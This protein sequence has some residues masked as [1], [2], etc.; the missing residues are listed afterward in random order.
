MPELPEVET[1]RR[2]I[3][4]SCE[5][6]TIEKLVLRRPDLRWPI[7]IDLAQQIEGHKILAIKRR[8]KY[9]LFELGHGTLIIH[10]GMSGVLKMVQPTMP[11]TKHDHVDLV[12]S[13]GICLRLNDTRRFGAVLWADASLLHPLLA[14]LGPEPLAEEFNAKLLF[15]QSRKRSIAIKLLI[16]DS[17]IVVG[18]GNIYANEALFHAKIHPETPANK[19]NRQQCESL[20]N[21]IKQV[22]NRAIE[23]G[24]TTL[25]DYRDGKGKP[26]YFQQELFVYGRSGKPCLICDNSLKETRMGQRTTVFCTECQV[27]LYKK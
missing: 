4:P 19:L 2:S 16:M 3:L 17:H 12:L 18:V 1:V 23:Q 20:V 8:A 14:K 6:Q 15:D 5:G 24:G 13:S 11:V 22:L 10:L 26:G 7:P 25:K 21:A 9:L 27:Q